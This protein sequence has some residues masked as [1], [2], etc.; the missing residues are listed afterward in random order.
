MTHWPRW[1]HRLPLHTAGSAFRHARPCHWKLS[2]THNRSGRA[3]SR[4]LFQQIVGGG[5][6]SRGAFTIAPVESLW[7]WAG[8]DGAVEPL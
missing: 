7:T 5:E 6:C 3:A 4:P 8:R 2:T 1:A